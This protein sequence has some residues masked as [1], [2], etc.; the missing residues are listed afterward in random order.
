MS[1]MRTPQAC[2]AN[3]MMA[4]NSHAALAR[5]ITKMNA[6]DCGASEI[7]ALR[8]RDQEVAEYLHAR[9]RFQLFRIDEI[10]VEHDALRFREQLHQ[11]VIFLDQIIRQHRDAETL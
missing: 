3:P 1:A 4:A 2:T 5:M 10:G 7:P 8:L 6:R 9:D 11:S